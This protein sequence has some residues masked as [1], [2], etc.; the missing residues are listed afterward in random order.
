MN[1][2]APVTE[3][4]AWLR[5]A[6]AVHERNA[7]LNGTYA[8]NAMTL[9]TFVSLFPLILLVVSVTGL[10]TGSHPHLVDDLVDNLGLTG[11]AAKTFRTT[12]TSARSSGTTGSIIG[13]IGIA[14]SGLAIVGALRYVVNLPRR[15]TV[16]GIR[17]RLLGLPW[18]A[19]SALILV[20]SVAISTLMNW[21]PGW[22]APLAIV[23]GLAVD[24]ALFGW[25]FWFLDE[26]RPAPRTL[27]PGVVLA[28]VGFEILKA[29]GAIAVPR[30]VAQSSAT[31]GTIGTVF[32]LLA[33]LLIFSRLVVY[34]VVLNAVY[35][36]RAAP[37]PA[38]DSTGESFTAATAQDA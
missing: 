37:G 24:A 31:Y 8:A 15:M 30:L 35:P 7:D 9:V 36:D 38:T 17:A 19:G 29:V 32:A 33:W 18:L 10:L 26:R 22:T 12:L 34:S 20:V 14:W 28:A 6:I 13:L 27:V 4:W 25:T 11:Q 21:L 2:K 3:R 23:V 16:K 5:L 1:P